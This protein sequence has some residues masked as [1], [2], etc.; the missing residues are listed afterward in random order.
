M[1]VS[2]KIRLTGSVEI[3]RG[4][5]MYTADE[6]SVS[7]QDFTLFQNS[8]NPFNPSTTLSCEIPY[9]AH[10]ML[11]V[12]NV[13]GQLV[14]VITDEM[15]AAGLHSFIWDASEMPSGVFFYTIKVNGTTRTKKMLLLK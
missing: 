8:P 15:K 6:L 5:A 7:P 14:T 13:E 10:V 12:Y 3:A 2:Y 11:S 1:S 4:K 9:D